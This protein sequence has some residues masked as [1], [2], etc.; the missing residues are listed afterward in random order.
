MKVKYCIFDVGKVCYD[1]TLDPLNDYCR[2]MS[3][4]PSAFDAVNGVKSFDYNPYMRGEVRF[5][6]M[7]EALC[8]HC[9]MEFGKDTL[10]KFDKLMHQGIGPI[11]KETFAAM[12][13]LKNNGVKI[14]LLSNALPNLSDNGR[15]VTGVD[16]VFVSYKMGM[17]KPDVRIFEAVLS[18]LQAC[19]HEV[20]FFDDKQK[21]VD[22]AASLG[23]HAFVF[24]RQTI[25]ENVK[26]LL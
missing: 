19:P 12:K 25:I 10:K 13:F 4:D 21:N 1:Y 20:A 18:E 9:R 14:C 15:F 17:L 22:A 24:D 5:Y 6:E 8:R 26:E 3:E 7:C 11:F 2:Q 23:I 16:H